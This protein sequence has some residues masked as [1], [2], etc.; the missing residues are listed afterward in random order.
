M[1]IH[2]KKPTQIKACGNKPKIILE[3][4]GRVNTKTQE[5]SVAHMKSPSGWREPGQTPEFNEYTV[6]LKGTLQV[7]SKNKTFNVKKGE[8]VLT[9]AGEWVQY[10]TPGKSGAEYIAIC[11]PAF[12]PDTVHRDN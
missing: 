3:H 5:I 12:S 8:A 1:P 2:V 4:I 9:Q 7:K 10:G 11:L 6:V